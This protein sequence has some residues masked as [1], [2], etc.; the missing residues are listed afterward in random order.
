MVIDYNRSKDMYQRVQLKK[1]LAEQEQ[2]LIRADVIRTYP[3]N[4]YFKSEEGRAAL[5]RILTSLS[6]H[7]SSAGYT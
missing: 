6:K 7:S 2:K 4:P 3:D 1:G 5:N